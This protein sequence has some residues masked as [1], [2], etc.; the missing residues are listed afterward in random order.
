VNDVAVPSLIDAETK[1][2]DAPADH[3]ADLRLWLRLLTCTTMIESEIRR[4]LRDE[5]AFTLPRFDFLAQL[6][7][8]PDGLVL[9]E[10]SRRLMVSAGNVTA[11][12]ERLLADGFIT[13]THSP[14]DRRIQVVRLTPAGRRRFRRM[15]EKHGGW[16]SELFDELP[17]EEVGALMESLGRLKTSIRRV[18]NGR[19]GEE[20]KAGGDAP[21]AGP[22]GRARA[23]RD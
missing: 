14:Q 16:V 13:R 21:V 22:R 11:I 8:A 15:A 3:R 7:K 12:T 18:T 5:F 20:S 19:P 2:G 10:V 17:E 6:D 4:R 9:G 1:V 23:S